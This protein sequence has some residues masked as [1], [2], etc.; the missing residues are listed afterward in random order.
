M[1]N[2][3]KVCGSRERWDEVEARWQCLY[4]ESPFAIKD[5]VKENNNIDKSNCTFSQKDEKK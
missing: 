2:Y 3:C 5:C 1:M 4:C